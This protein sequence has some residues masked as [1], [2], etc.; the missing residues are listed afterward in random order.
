LP[1][2]TRQVGASIEKEFGVVSESRSGLVAMLH[3]LGLEYHKPET[4]GRKLDPEKQQARLWGVM[5]K[6]LEFADAMLHFLRAEVPSRWGEI[7]DSI[8]DNFRM[9]RPANFRILA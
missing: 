7:A 4:I 1:R 6:S 2:T 3:R 9:I 8:T 5:H